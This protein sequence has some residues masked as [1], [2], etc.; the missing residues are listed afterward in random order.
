LKYHEIWFVA[1]GAAAVANALESRKKWDGSWAPSTALTK[2]SPD[3]EWVLVL[4]VVPQG[5]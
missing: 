2:M 5:E 1:A 4:M 3:G